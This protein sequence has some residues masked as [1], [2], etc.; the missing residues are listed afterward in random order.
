MLAKLGVPRWEEPLPFD[1]ARCTMDGLIHFAANSKQLCAD[2]DGMGFFPTKVRNDK[3]LL[4]YPYDPVSIWLLF[5]A[6]HTAITHF[7]INTSPIQVMYAQR[8]RNWNRFVNRSATGGSLGGTANM[9]RTSLAVNPLDEI[10]VAPR[11]LS[12][13]DKGGSGGT[14]R[15]DN[16]LVLVLHQQPTGAAVEVLP[17]SAH[18]GMYPDDNRI[19]VWS[20]PHAPGGG[21]LFDRC[22]DGYQEI[23]NRTSDPAFWDPSPARGRRT[24]STSGTKWV[25]YREIS[26][27][28]GV[29]AFRGSCMGF[30][31]TLGGGGASCAYCGSTDGHA[32]SDATHFDSGRDWLDEDSTTMATVLFQQVGVGGGQD[33]DIVAAVEAVASSLNRSANECLPHVKE[34]LQL[35]ATEEA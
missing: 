16:H 7:D 20:L 25:T 22:H 30:G 35:F 21:S 6:Q 12:T 10:R 18:L 8:L 31:S 2:P 13:L 19:S 27:V 3:G 17:H 33:V 4:A 26:H 11:L 28:E 23:I 29:P 14:S 1:A 32:L 5:R 15:A 24:L 9:L 34:F